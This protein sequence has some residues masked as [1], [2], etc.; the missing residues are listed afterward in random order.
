M[1]PSTHL[2]WNVYIILLKSLWEHIKIPVNRFNMKHSSDIQQRLHSI[3]QQNYLIPM[4]RP[5]AR[6]AVVTRRFQYI[7]CSRFTIT[8]LIFW[9]LECNR[10]QISRHDL[11]VHEFS[12][13]TICRN[14]GAGHWTLSLQS[15]ISQ[16]HT[17]NNEFS[18]NLGRSLR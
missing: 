2:Q 11:V 18:N 8:Y 16:V 14:L 6:H 3:L 9:T 5:F 13:R 10:S 15:K 1:L 7:F 17:Y 4:L 12:G